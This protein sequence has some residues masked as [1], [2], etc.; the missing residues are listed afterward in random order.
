MISEEHRILSSF[1]PQCK[2]YINGKE[3]RKLLSFLKFRLWVLAFFDQRRSPVL[4]AKL[5]EMEFW[6]R[7]RTQRFF[8]GLYQ[9]P[10]TWC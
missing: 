3:S 1:S 9:I 7:I 6:Y 8:F 10:I 5:V 4:W 2:Q